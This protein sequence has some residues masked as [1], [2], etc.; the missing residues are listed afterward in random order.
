MSQP[1]TG[2]LPSISNT[3]PAATVPST[4]AWNCAPAFR[5]AAASAAQARALLSSRRARDARVPVRSLL[6]TPTV[7]G[8]AA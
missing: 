8:M 2:S 5:G 6:A 7:P 4:L 3:R 1:G